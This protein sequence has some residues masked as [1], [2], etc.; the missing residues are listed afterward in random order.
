MSFPLGIFCNWCCRDNCLHKVKSTSLGC[1]LIFSWSTLARITSIHIC[2]HAI[3]WDSLFSHGMGGPHKRD[4][5]P[6]FTAQIPRSHRWPS[7]FPRASIAVVTSYIQHTT[8]GVRTAAREQKALGGME[9]NT[10][11]LMWEAKCPSSGPWVFRS[12]IACHI[13]ISPVT[14]TKSAYDCHLV[15]ILGISPVSFH[16][17]YGFP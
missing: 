12:N 11:S 17:L 3:H 7:A 13:P 5:F 10:R 14:C 8:Y 6:F 2:E 16:S 15:T 1:L 4:I 9:P